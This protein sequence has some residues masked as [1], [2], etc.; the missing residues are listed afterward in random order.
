MNFI[1]AVQALVDGAKYA[2]SR[3]RLIRMILSK[4][5][6]IIAFR[7]DLN[8]KVRYETILISDDVLATDWEVVK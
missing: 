1:E 8:S 2:D 5:L 3:T 6:K 4:S 7:I